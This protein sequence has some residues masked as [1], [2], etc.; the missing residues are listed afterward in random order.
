MVAVPG[1]AASQGGG[2]G[3]GQR[4]A[5][6]RARKW[7][8]HDSELRPGQVVGWMLLVWERWGF[9]TVKGKSA[10]EGIH[11]WFYLG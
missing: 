7:S 6:P 1:C 2:S 11:A 4:V 8:P 9:S 5:A 10:Y 3:V